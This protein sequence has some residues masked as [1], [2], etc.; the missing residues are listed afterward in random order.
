[1]F[2]SKLSEEEEGMFG[3][4]GQPSPSDEGEDEAEAWGKHKAAQ[5][6]KPPSGVCHPALTANYTGAA[7]YVY[8]SFDDQVGWGNLGLILLQVLLLAVATDRTPVLT[9]AHAVSLRP[10][11]ELTPRVRFL[12]PP[13]PAPP[14]AVRIGGQLRIGGR[15][16]PRNAG[17]EQIAADVARVVKHPLAPTTA[18]AVGPSLWTYETVHG[19]LKDAWRLNRLVENSS[20]VAPAFILPKSKVAQAVRRAA[21]GTTAVHVRTCQPGG[22]SKGANGSSVFH[23]TC[24]KNNRTILTWADAATAVVAAARS[25]TPPQQSTAGALFL[26][27]DAAEVFSKVRAK[28][29][30][31]IRSFEELGRLVNY[32]YKPS[33]FKTVDMDR[34]VYDW[35]APVY[36]AKIIE[37][38]PSSFWVASLCL[39]NPHKD[40]LAYSESK[41][42]D[43]SKPPVHCT[44]SQAL[45]YWPI[46]SR[47]NS[48]A[49]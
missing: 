34:I 48:R 4:G 15:L 10:Y 21:A 20:C 22:G 6:Y 43:K 8:L 23:D 5:M 18:I 37:I 12:S 9:G 32:R 19:L 41:N 7:G 35:M 42:E 30:T 28:W 38:S 24:A 3:R 16:L 13:Q 40:Y 47:R 25:Q 1:M 33:S 46:R 36:A 45:C 31:P 39:F 44:V 26:A 27:A 17:P 11:F 2:S 49:Q 29:H 14:D